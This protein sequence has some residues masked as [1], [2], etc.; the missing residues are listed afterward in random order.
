MTSVYHEYCSECCLGDKRPGN[1]SRGRAT[2]KLHAIVRRRTSHTHVLCVLQGVGI[3]DL[4]AR[5][6]TSPEKIGAHFPERPSVVEVHSRQGRILRVLASRFIFREVRPG[7]LLLF[8]YL[9]PETML[10][11]S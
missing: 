2:G 11:F 10:R 7:P 4:G 1:R 6:H 9:E 8:L 5:A 3:S